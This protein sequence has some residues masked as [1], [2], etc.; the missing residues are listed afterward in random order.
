[1][2][3]NM[4]SLCLDNE[5]L[6]EELYDT[7]DRIGSKSNPNFVADLLDALVDK[8]L[9][10]DDDFPQT[11]LKIEDLLSFAMMYD[12]GMDYA[13]E[14]EFIIESFKEEAGILENN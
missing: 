5:E 1:M 3:S 13:Y 7:Q 14:M 8:L 12:E 10:L 2:M 6:L 11:K 4:G 9:L